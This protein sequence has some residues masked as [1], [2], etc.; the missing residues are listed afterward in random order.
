MKCYPG[1][2]SKTYLYLQFRRAFGIFT[3]NAVE[4]GFPCSCKRLCPRIP[5]LFISKA[6]VWVG[7]LKS[8]SD[9]WV[10]LQWPLPLGLC[11]KQ[12]KTTQRFAQMNTS[13]KE[14]SG[15]QLHFHPA[16]LG[17]NHFGSFRVIL[18]SYLIISI[19]EPSKMWKYYHKMNWFLDSF[20]Q[21]H[22]SDTRAVLSY[23]LWQLF[24]AK[25]RKIWL[26]WE[27]FNAWN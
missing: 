21:T 22:H 1:T 20:T 26:T 11:R 12:N 5:L 13:Q 14:K 10:Q 9:P 7:W 15:L 6:E 4:S 8:D 18:K 24:I 23:Y 17:W 19:L 27:F 2:V 25:L 3:G 16:L